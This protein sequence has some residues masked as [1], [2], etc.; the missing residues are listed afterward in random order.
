MTVGADGKATSTGA[1][2]IAEAQA[3]NNAS[4]AKIDAIVE[5][6]R[7]FRRFR[8]IGSGLV[9]GA[10]YLSPTPGGM[11]TASFFFSKQVGVSVFGG[12][13]PDT[14]YRS[15]LENGFG[16]A[17]LEIVPLRLSLGRFDDL[18]EVGVLAGASSMARAAG[19]WQ[20]INLSNACFD[21]T[22]SSVQYGQ[23]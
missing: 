21:Q 19:N 8:V 6:P 10:N 20:R 17:E 23:P 13:I 5:R 16:G 7:E 14:G 9:A 1:P 18:L 3:A 12:L 2:A 15:Y 11:L 4:T 22:Q